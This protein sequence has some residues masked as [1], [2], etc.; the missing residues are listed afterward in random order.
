MKFTIANGNTD[1][2]VISISI[3]KRLPKH[4]LVDNNYR[5][6]AALS[7][8]ILYNLFSWLKTL[9]IK[10]CVLTKDKKCM[11]FQSEHFM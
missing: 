8:H 7:P 9:Y 4:I 1:E 10:L 11:I 5:I 2:K 6:I 3:Y